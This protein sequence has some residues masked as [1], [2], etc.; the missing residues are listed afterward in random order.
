[1]R[2]FKG[3]G[4]APATASAQMDEPTASLDFGNQALVLRESRALAT[5]GYGIVLSTHDPDHAFACASAVALLHGGHLVATG[6]PSDM[7]E[8]VYGLPVA[9]ERLPGGHTVCV[10]DLSLP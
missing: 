6:A 4:K 3:T 8:A 2:R 1:L 9:V 7:F 10:P 5:H